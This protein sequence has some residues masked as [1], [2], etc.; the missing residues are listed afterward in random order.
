[1]SLLKKIYLTLAD[2]SKEAGAEASNYEQ[3]YKSREEAGEIE[4]ELVSLYDKYNL[5]GGTHWSTFNNNATT[6]DQWL[7]LLKMK[8]SSDD[9]SWQQIYEND[10]VIRM[11]GEM[12]GNDEIQN[13]NFIRG[14]YAN[15]ILKFK[16]IKKEGD[17]LSKSKNKNIILNRAYTRY[18]FRDEEKT[19]DVAPD[20]LDQ[21]YVKFGMLLQFIEEYILLY[22]RK[23]GE[24]KSLFSIDWGF[25]DNYCLTFPL[26]YSSDPRICIFSPLQQIMEGEA[27]YVDTVID[28]TK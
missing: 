27:G 28:Q 5:F 11:E 19:A 3:N 26:H 4:V 16:E 13:Y 18:A 14:K 24:K 15:H 7:Y 25:N 22:Q 23:N 1:M 6:V 21:Y 2:Y 20:Q 12:S 8:L 10:T 9:T 17:S